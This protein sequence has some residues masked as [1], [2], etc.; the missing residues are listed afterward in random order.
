[1]FVRMWPEEGAEMFAGL[2]QFKRN[3]DGA[4]KW[5][6]KA[7]GMEAHLWWDVYGDM[8]NCT[9]L[10][11]AAMYLTSKTSSASVAEQGV[12]G[13]SKVGAIETNKRL[14]IHTATTD[15]LVNI[16][17]VEW[18]KRE[19]AKPADAKRPNNLDLF[20]CLHEMIID[21]QEKATALEL[22][23]AP[24]DATETE[25]EG[26]VGVD[27]E[28]DD[29]DEEVAVDRMATREEAESGY[30]DD[31]ASGYYSDTAF[32]VDDDTGHNPARTIVRPNDSLIACL[33]SLAS[34]KGTKLNATRQLAFDAAE[35]PN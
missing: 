15:K 22:S 32:E 3:G 28:G 14:R 4:F 6:P 35:E 23:E 16:C 17:G 1:M 9:A 12:V 33:P 7:N 27:G 20:E 19:D 24:D 11:Q 29:E 5:L 30:A 18:C 10:V 34:I 8:V 25:T 2:S 21:V 13:W 26:Q 31:D